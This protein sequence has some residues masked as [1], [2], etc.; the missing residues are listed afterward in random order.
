MVLL[1]RDEMSSQ[2]CI[3]LD[4]RQLHAGIDVC[5]I[6]HGLGWADT[7]RWLLTPSSSKSVLKLTFRTLVSALTRKNQL[8]LKFLFYE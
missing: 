5:V 1:S 3:G 8:L 6:T 7:T 2:R 4:R